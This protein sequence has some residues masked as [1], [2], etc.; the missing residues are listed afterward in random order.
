MLSSVWRSYIQPMLKRPAN[1]QV[2]ALCYRAAPTGLEVLMITSRETRR[3]IL[4]KGWP[5]AGRRSGGAAAQEAWEEAGVIAA[6][7]PPRLIGR[8]RYDKIA[9]GGLPM[10]TDVDVFA[11]E[12]ARLAD[13]FP[14]A[15]QRE[16]R[17]MAPAAAAQLVAEPDLAQL[18]RALPVLPCAAPGAA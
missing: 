9:D 13:D 17:W 12:V 4:P 10:P 18:L 3:W 6:P 11:I 7:R 8:Y 1:L 15:H 14:E 5:M 2:A 16:R